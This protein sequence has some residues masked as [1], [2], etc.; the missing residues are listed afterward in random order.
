[1]T[2]TRSELEKDFT[3]LHTLLRKKEEQ[4][5]LKTLDRFIHTHGHESFNSINSTMFVKTKTLSGVD[6]TMTLLCFA[7]MRNYQFKTDSIWRTH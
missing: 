1:M 3:I 5:A 6:C 4:K 2:S 7:V